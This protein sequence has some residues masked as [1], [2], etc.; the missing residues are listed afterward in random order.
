[1]FRDLGITLLAQAA[2]AFGGLL[3]YRLLAR[4]LGTSAF[5]EF[6]LVKQAATIVSPVVTIGTDGRTAALSR[7]STAG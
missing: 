2:V 6:S 7:T 5:A 3:L 4:E 1:M